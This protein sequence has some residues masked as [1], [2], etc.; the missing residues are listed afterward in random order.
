MTDMM[1]LIRSISLI[2]TVFF[3]LITQTF[4]YFPK[5]RVFSEVYFPVPE[6]NRDPNSKIIQ[7]HTQSTK[8]FSTVGTYAKYQVQSYMATKDRKRKY[9]YD[10]NVVEMNKM[11]K[12]GTNVDLR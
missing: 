5:K 6:I 12:F 9:E 4:L 2:Q 7:W 1:L 10:E 3:S 8:S 11:I